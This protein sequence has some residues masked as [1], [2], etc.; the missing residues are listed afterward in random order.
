MKAGETVLV[1]PR[2]VFDG[3]SS[4]LRWASACDLE[5]FLAKSAGSFKWMDRSD[6]ETSPDWIQPIPSALVRDLNGRYYALKRSGKGRAD[7]RRRI[8]LTVGGHV[9]P[10]DNHSS[11]SLP[12]LLHVLHDTLLRELKEELDIERV[13]SV[14]PIGLIFDLPSLPLSRH[15]IAL[16]RHVAFLSETIVDQPVRPQAH[17]EFTLRSRSSHV[18]RFLSVDELARHRRDLDRWSRIVFSDYLMPGL[19]APEGTAPSVDSSAEATPPGVG[20]E[21]A[22][23]RIDAQRDPRRHTQP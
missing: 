15:T 12:E 11:L 20:S 10:S 23:Q 19:W 2:D 9:E 7:M 6:A 1:M 21:Q 3:H 13:V 18:N 5:D 22:E 16:S 8:G 4:F 17:E 14:R